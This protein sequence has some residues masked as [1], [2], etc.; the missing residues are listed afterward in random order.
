[1]LFQSSGLKKIDT[2]LNFFSEI[3][4]VSYPVCYSFLAV[5]PRHIPI[6]VEKGDEL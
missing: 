4:R 6:I 2:H 3:C 5:G 1:M